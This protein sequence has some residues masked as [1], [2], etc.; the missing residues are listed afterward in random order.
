MAVRDLKGKVALV[1]GATS[2]IGLET[3]AALASEWQ[4][5]ED[6]CLVDD[7]SSSS[8]S[9]RALDI[10]SISNPYGLTSAVRGATVIL[11]CRNREAALKV[12]A[13]IKWVAQL[14]DLRVASSF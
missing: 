4:A 12:M 11:G 2:G 1:T 10:S 8:C 6:K 7:E 14:L 5:A 9:T 3:A 13:E